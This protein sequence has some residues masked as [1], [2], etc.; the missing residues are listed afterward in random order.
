[1]KFSPQGADYSTSLGGSLTLG[2]HAPVATGMDLLGANATYTIDPDG[3]NQTA[4]PLSELA[5][6][7]WAR[8]NGIRV[9]SRPIPLSLT[10]TPADPSSPTEIVIQSYAASANATVLI[11]CLADAGANSF[12]VP[13]DILAN[14]PLSYRIADGSYTVLF[15]GS[16]K[17]LPVSSG[18]AN[19]VLVR[20]NWVGQTV[21]TQ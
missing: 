20:S 9:I 11:Q 14:L 17:T 3:P 12:T 21:V 4:I 13:A 7:T 8:T 15:I 2:N 1:M 5:P 10:F 6:P 19:G 18:L 16:F